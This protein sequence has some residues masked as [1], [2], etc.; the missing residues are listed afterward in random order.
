MAVRTLR[1]NFQL[2]RTKNACSCRYA[3]EIVFTLGFALGA[4][5]KEAWTM[6]ARD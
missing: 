2:P 6:V 1:L 5:R 3:A 4:Q